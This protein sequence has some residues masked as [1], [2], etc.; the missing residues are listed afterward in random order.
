M[1]DKYTKKKNLNADGNGE[2][3]FNFHFKS[4]FIGFYENHSMEARKKKKK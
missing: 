3:I 1:I 2:E 4:T